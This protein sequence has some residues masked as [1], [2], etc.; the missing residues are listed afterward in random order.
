MFA[1][2]MPQQTAAKKRSSPRSQRKAARAAKAAGS[3]AGNPTQ[4]P[5]PKTLNP[6]KPRNNKTATGLAATNDDDDTGDAD[7][8]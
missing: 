2:E 1:R 6:K 5:K 3:R 7:D 4:K 8:F